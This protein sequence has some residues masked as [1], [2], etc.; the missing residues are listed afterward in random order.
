MEE[1]GPLSMSTSGEYANLRICRRCRYGNHDLDHS[2]MG[3]LAVVWV[4]G[5][6]PTRTR[7]DYICACAVVGTSIA[8]RRAFMKNR[9]G[10]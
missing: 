3:C 5:P 4:P 2:E 10:S 8:R 7:Q 6:F 9:L 1:P